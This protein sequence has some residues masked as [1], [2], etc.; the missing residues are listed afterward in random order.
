MLGIEDVFISKLDSEGN[1]VWAK[2]VGGTS[3]DAAEHAAHWQ[4][5]LRFLE[6][7][8][9]YLAATGPTEGQGRMRAAADAL[10]AA[11]AETQYRR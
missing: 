8:A 10:A 6:L 11:W 9:G 3:V 7:I 1:F 5:S 2:A 4:R